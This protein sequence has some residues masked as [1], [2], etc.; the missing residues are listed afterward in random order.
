MSIQT[1]LSQL[2]PNLRLFFMRYI[3]A[4]KSPEAALASVLAGELP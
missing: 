3:F 2:T 4:G 1:A